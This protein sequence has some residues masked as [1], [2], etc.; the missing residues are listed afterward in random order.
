MVVIKQSGYL[1]MTFFLV[2][3]EVCQYLAN[4]LHVG[5]VPTC[6]Y[7]AWYWQPA[8]WSLRLD[9]SSSTTS[10]LTTRQSKT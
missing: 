3:L 9:Q 4:M 7:H 2:Y 8:T 6:L 5:R 10:G 1:G